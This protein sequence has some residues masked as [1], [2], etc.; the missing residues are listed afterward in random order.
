MKYVNTGIKDEEGRWIHVLRENKKTK[1][2]DLN[3]LNSQTCCFI[4]D[5]ISHRIT[6]GGKLSINLML[7]IERVYAIIITVDK[8]D[9]IKEKEVEEFIKLSEKESETIYKTGE[10]LFLTDKSLKKIAERYLESKKH[11]SDYAFSLA[12]CIHLTLGN[13]NF[14]IGFSKAINL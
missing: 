5:K 6:V 7:D 10:R 13:D 1:K 12:A 14:Y 4:D 2:I 9:E 3:C 8:F 11:I